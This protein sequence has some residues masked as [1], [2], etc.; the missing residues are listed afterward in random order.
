MQQYIAT[1]VAPG[2]RYF[3]LLR[4]L[5]EL[6]IAHLMARTTRYDKYFTSCNR[7][8]AIRENVPVQR[9]CCNCPKCRFAFLMFATIM[10]RERLCSIFG[11]NLLDDPTQITGYEELTGMSGH[12]PWECVGEI[13]ESSAA[14]L[15]LD[16]D[17]THSQAA[18]VR[19]LAPR[20]H[21][22]M[23]N[24]A[25]QYDKLL[26]PSNMHRLPKRYEEMLYA[27]LANR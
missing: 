7:N 19:A 2:L 13:E 10:P 6:R 16:P 23:P 21:A 1:N 8:F 27:Y 14:L 22:L 4:P 26:T 18:V 15:A 11:A 9:W 3:S 5:S 25:R 12:K 24:P 20:L 17:P